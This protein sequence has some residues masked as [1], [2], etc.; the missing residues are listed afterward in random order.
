M[1]L[2]ELGW[3]AGILDG[4]GTITAYW[5]KTATGGSSLHHMVSVGMTDL[6][7]IKVI[8][9]LIWEITGLKYKIGQQRAKSNPNAKM[10]YK[11]QVVRRAAVRKIT[12]LL[13]DICV[14]KKRQA[15]LVWEITTRLPLW[16]RRPGHRIDRP[17]WLDEIITELKELNRRGIPSQEPKG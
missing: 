14:T 16:H 15:E 4:E 17:V 7:T 11:L 6:K 13:K 8:Q 2:S 1:Q 12:E 9:K 5:N 10:C 3:L